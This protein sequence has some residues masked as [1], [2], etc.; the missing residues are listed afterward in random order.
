M[1]LDGPFR[2]I[3]HIDMDA[4][5]ASIEQRDAPELRGKPVAV[6]GSAERGVVAAASYEA[7]IFGVHSAM[8]SFLAKRKC[9]E[10]IF[11]PH[12]FDVYKSV[13]RQVMDIF[14]E[15]TDLVEPL[16]LDEA[17]LDVTENKMGF[18][19]G[20]FVAQKIRE[21]ILATTQL[22]A[23]AGISFNKF[24]A[25]TASDLNKPNGQA[26]ILPQDALA[27]IDQLPVG[28]FFGVGKKTG[29]KLEA[30]G[31]HTGAD[32]RN[33]E[34]AELIR[35]FG[36]MGNHF[37][38]I[39]RGEDNRPVK[40][41]RIRKSIGA[42][43]TYESDLTLPAEMEEK[44]ASIAEKVDKVLK[45]TGSAGRTVTLK[46]KYFDFEQTTR[47]RTMPRYVSE[48]SEV[49]QLARELLYQPDFPSKPVRLLGISL[50]NLNT[51]TTSG[52]QLQLEL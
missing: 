25:K 17:F 27:F 26:V 31:I 32:L 40:P 50:S 33:L 28:K 24:L 20:M 16:S 30:I 3:I 41:D 49:L 23:S 51:E 12:R 8:P 2:K 6:G 38:K 36:K 47:S 34:Q 35:R 7:R 43:R 42:E 44:L 37:Y 52:E 45:R 9:P 5:F 11:V 1:N 4:F 14:Q 10:L 18:K 19:S 39:V 15:Y 21:Q 48:L 22:T 13:S 29:E 46:I